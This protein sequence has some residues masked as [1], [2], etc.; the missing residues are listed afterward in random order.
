MGRKIRLGITNDDIPRPGLKRLDQMSNIE[1]Q[2]FSESLPEVSAEQIRGFDM[3]V[4]AGASWTQQTVAG[5]KDL[6]CVLYLGMGYDHIDVLALNKAE[7]MLCNSPMAVRRPMAVTIMTFI[8][9]LAMRLLNKDKI[10]R[11]VRWEK[12]EDYYGDGLAGK[13]LCSG[14]GGNI[15]H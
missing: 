5:N 12:K 14:P 7:V 10:T 6:I 8:L 15:G 11:E 1:Y 4:T 3:V 2:V 13:K 9:A